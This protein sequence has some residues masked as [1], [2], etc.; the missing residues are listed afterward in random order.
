MPTPFTPCPHLLN[1]VPHV[2]D[3]NAD[4]EDALDG[5]DDEV[6]VIHRGAAGNGDLNS[7]RKAGRTRLFTAVLP[8][9]VT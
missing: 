3:D 4:Q 9:M 2:G 7:V 8:A 5:N 1:H 6:D